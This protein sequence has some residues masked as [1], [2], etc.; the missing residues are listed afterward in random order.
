MSQPIYAVARLE[1]SWPYSKSSPLVAA[2]AKG[3]LAD[4]EAY[5]VRLRANAE[6][7]ARREL[8]RTRASLEAKVRPCQGV[9]ACVQAH[10]L[11]W[12][13]AKASYRGQVAFISK[14]Y[15]LTYM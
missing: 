6:G 3:P 4:E 5:L 8:D 11:A 9:A 7:E 15:C 14:V 12:W 1:N 13:W 2:G 10:A